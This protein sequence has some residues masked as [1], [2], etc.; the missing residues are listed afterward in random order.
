MENS[1]DSSSFDIL[2]GNRLC[3]VLEKFCFMKKYIAILF[4][5]SYRNT[6]PYFAGKFSLS[7]YR[8]RLFCTFFGVSPSFI[9]GISSDMFD[10]NTILSLE[11]QLWM[12]SHGVFVLREDNLR[13][14]FSLSVK[15]EYANS[16]RRSFYYSLEQR[17]F[18]IFYLNVLSLYFNKDFS[19]KYNFSKAFIASAKKELCSLIFKY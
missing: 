8:L 18:I 1:L 5:I 15:D 9:L 16:E 17:A 14:C 2:L 13:C 4:N 7:S 6:I 10:E 11:S 19:S 12:Y 3:L